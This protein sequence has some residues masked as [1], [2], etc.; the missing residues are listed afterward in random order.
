MTHDGH[1][2]PLMSDGLSERGRMR[3]DEI[4]EVALRAQHRRRV[5]RR[6]VRGALAVAPVVVIVGAAWLVMSG[7]GPVTTPSPVGPIA[8]AP[9]QHHAES[10]PAINDVPMPSGVRLT[11]TPIKAQQIDDAELLALLAEAGRPDGLV[12]IDGVTMLAS[13]LAQRQDDERPSSPQGARPSDI[14]RG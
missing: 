3:R 10:A 8:E 1:E 2:M 12:R 11:S 6:A 5:R 9:S 7:P 13:E 4:L 14:T